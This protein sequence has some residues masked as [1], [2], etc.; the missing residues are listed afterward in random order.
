MESNFNKDLLIPEGEEEEKKE[1]Q[2]SFGNIQE[3]EVRVEEE[4]KPINDDDSDLSEPIGKKEMNTILSN[5]N[6]Y[7]I[8]IMAS[9][10]LF[11]YII[12]YETLGIFILA[13]II[14]LIGLGSLELISKSIEF[15]IKEVGLKWFI[16]IEIFNHLSVGFFCLTTFS[17]I[18][19]ESKNIKKFFLYNGTKV[20]L[21]YL[22]SIII[23]EGIINEGIQE[24]IKKK[25]KEYTKDFSEEKKNKLLEMFN[26]L[27]DSSLIIV[28]NFLATYNLFLDKFVLG[29]LYIFLFSTPNKING[30]KKVLFRVLSIFPIL[31]ILSSLI[32]R[33]LQTIKTIKLNPLV[34]PIFLGS[35]ITIYGFFISTLCIIKYKSLKYNVYDED[36]NIYPKVFTK[37]GSKTFS[38]FGFIELFAG[39]FFSYWSKVGIGGKYLL[40]L[41]AP[42]ITLYDYKKKSKVSLCCD[43]KKDISKCFKIAF[44]IV[45]YF[46]II[47]LGILLL[48]FMKVLISEYLSPILEIFLDNIDIF[49]EIIVSIT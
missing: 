12:I 35:K 22:L 44:N 11:L 26:K 42:L 37:I 9:F 46:I 28:G 19:L 41:C 43:K 6:C 7:W 24:Y 14:G 10:S 5:L 47:I 13:S 39:L 18:F 4:I 45:G 31:F 1:D 3:Q 17:N 25:I 34:S 38:F 32:L 27:M 30:Y 15:F 8:E 16:L 21:Y 48:I 2:I 23:L 33:G 29:C 49:L 20:I 40:I 36:E